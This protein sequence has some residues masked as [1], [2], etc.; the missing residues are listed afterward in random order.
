MHAA[1][2]RAKSAREVAEAGV[3]AGCEFDTSSAA[4]VRL[5]TLTL[6]LASN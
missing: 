4:P 1:Y 2:G 3:L 5:H 6:K